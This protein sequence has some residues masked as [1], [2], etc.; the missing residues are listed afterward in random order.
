MGGNADLRQHIHAV[1]VDVD[2]GIG[3]GNALEEAKQ[4]G[5][6][7]NVQRLPVAEDHDGQ[8]QEAKARHIAVAGAVGGGQGVDKAAHAR[9]STGNGGAGIA[10]LVDIDAQAVCRLRILAAGPKPQTE[11]GL[12]QQDGHNNEEQD[13]DVGS[14]IHLVQEGLSQKADILALGNA[15]GGLFQHKPGGGIAGLHIQD[16]LAVDDPDEKQ[17]HG[18]GHQVQGGAADGLVRLQID[19]GEAQQQA[20][21]STQSGGHQH[22]HNFQALQ[23]QPGPL[24]GSVHEH[25]QVLH[26][27]DEEDTDERAKNHDAFQRQVDDAAALGEHT[28]QGHDHQRNRVKQSLLNDECHFLAPPFSAFASLAG[29]SFFFFPSSHIRMTREKALR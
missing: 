4:Q 15:E 14:E 6:P 5:G 12:I 25:I 2:A 29:F 17:H 21:E 20:E 24:P 23:R 27:A 26:G 10:H 19:G 8:S 22:S 11:A 13:A 28:G 9:Q 7:G 16:I 1:S 3:S 18:G